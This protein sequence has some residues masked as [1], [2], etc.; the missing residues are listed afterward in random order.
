LNYFLSIIIILIMKPVIAKLK[1]GGEV[2]E[3][4]VYPRKSLEFKQG[5]GNIEE[6]IVSD[7]IFSDV[8]RGEKASSQNLNKNF[9]TEN[10]LEIAKK[11]IIY[12]E[13]QIPKE[14]RDEM[15]N[16]KKKQI[17]TIISKMAINPQTKLPHPI[18]RILNVMEKTGI[19]I[20]FYK[21]AEDQVKEVISKIR[22]EIP[23]SIEN[24]KME[25]KIPAKYSG[26]VYGKIKSLGKILR[27]NWNN[28]GSFSCILEIP[29]G[30]KND[31]YDKLGV[32][33]HG[34]ALIKEE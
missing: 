25:I 11:I 23:L 3:I 7:E 24:L 2:F 32:L 4:L 19:S 30:Q 6:V 15:L 13:I 18:E 34:E 33:T 27:E 26:S 22:T 16:K 5:K 10:K 21:N 1:K 9:G 8:E 12:G 14:L 20:N 29:A 28:D 31:V 17:A